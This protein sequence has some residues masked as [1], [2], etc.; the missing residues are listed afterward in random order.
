MIGSIVKTISKLEKIVADHFL[1]LG[2]SEK[3]STR[4]NK[5]LKESK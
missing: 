4:Q 5:R 1:D 3:L 2:K